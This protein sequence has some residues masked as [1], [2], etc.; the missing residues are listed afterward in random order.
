MKVEQLI[1]DL[2][3]E[4]SIP[5]EVYGNILVSI[6]E[7]I[8]N[9]IKHGNKF[10]TSKSVVFSFEVKEAGYQFTISD[11]GSGF[12]YENVPDPTHPD[13]LEKIDGRGIFIM[14]S[15]ADEVAYEENGSTVILTFNKV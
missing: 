5:E 9:A 8:N 12:D 15:L 3:E 2:K 4:F 6:S 1:D 13:N 10:D 7:G 14:E 11:Q